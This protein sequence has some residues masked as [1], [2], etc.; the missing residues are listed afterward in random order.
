MFVCQVGRQISFG[1]LRFHYEQ[2]SPR[3]DIQESA[4]SCTTPIKRQPKDSHEPFYPLSGMGMTYLRINDMRLEY[5]ECSM[6][7]RENVI[8]KRT[9]FGSVGR[10]PWFKPR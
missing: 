4:Q 8:K 10:L 6:M 3:Q 2:G 1:S 5:D 7:T 9:H